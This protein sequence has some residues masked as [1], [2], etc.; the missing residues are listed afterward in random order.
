MGIW[1]EWAWSNRMD[2]ATNI[3]LWGMFHSTLVLSNTLN[4]KPEYSTWTSLLFQKADLVLWLSGTPGSPSMLIAATRAVIQGL[5]K[6]NACIWLQSP[7]RDKAP[8]WAWNC[9]HRQCLLSLWPNSEIK[10][11]PGASSSFYSLSQSYY[12]HW[13][14]RVF[15]QGVMKK[16]RLA[17]IIELAG[18]QQW[19]S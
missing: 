2:L 17:P 12:P 7:C 15:P 5:T 6:V 1:M 18:P 3:R 8:Q 4:R 19:R 16:A 13:Y 9:P 11:S 10:Y 14:Q